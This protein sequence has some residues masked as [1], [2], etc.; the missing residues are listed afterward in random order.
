MPSSVHSASS[1][2]GSVQ[3]PISFWMRNFG[4]YVSYNH[5]LTQ[6]LRPAPGFSIIVFK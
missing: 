6:F 3:I 5:G 2:T 4:V 1:H